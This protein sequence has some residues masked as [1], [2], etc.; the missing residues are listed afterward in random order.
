MKKEDADEI[1]VKY[2]EKI[3][4][5]ASSRERDIDK[6]EEI[7]DRIVFNVY[8]SLLINEKI[9]HIDSYIYKI[10]CNVFADF[11]KE[12]NRYVQLSE[13]HQIDS[14]EDTSSEASNYSSEY[15]RL[16][17]EISYLTEIHRKVLEMFYF[18]NETLFEIAQ[19]LNVSPRNVK[20]HLSNARRKLKE[21]M[22]LEF[23]DI[24]EVN[25]I[26]FAGVGQHGSDGTNGEDVDTYFGKLI[27][28]NIAYSAYYEAKTIT[29]IARD[30][31]VAAVYI[32]NEIEILVENGYI[33]KVAG[34]K[35]L[36]NMLIIEPSVNALEQK[37][38]VYTKYAKYVCDFYVP[39]LFKLME[40]R[41]PQKIYTPKNDF[42]FLMW[43]VV[44]FASRFKLSL[45]DKSTFLK[46]FHVKR[47]DGGENIAFAWL[48]KNF[49]W[50]ELSYFQKLYDV[51]EDINS[52]SDEKKRSW[53]FNSYY[54]TR[55]ADI[56]DYTGIDFVDLYNHI[57]GKIT[58]IP[59]HVKRYAALYEKRYLI[60]IKDTDYVN[61]VVVSPTEKDFLNMLPDM[62]VKLKN[63]SKELD[64][65][66]FE[67]DKKQ[68]PSHMHSICQAWNTDVLQVQKL[69]HEC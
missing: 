1:I 51:L 24:T 34:N 26:K 62:S 4:G 13:E 9:E 15:S 44:S 35:Y 47:N 12:E 23:N 33:D 63:I 61:M 56:E 42:N 68:F 16:K 32:E 60:N 28:Q 40:Q 45:N 8:K 14:Y 50:Q 5:F 41:D 17:T 3:F 30:L 53:Q 25:H 52:F 2:L 18:K 6:A 43:S 39:L 36:T 29:E 59:K 20:W 19:K 66:I 37:H 31:R 64:K 21:G 54:D 67:I 49:K 58:K 55:E 65:E 46:K 10:S 69:G 7:A 27:A 11:V 22:M 38:Q 57:T 48:E